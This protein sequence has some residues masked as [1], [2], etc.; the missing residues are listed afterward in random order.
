M[1]SSSVAKENRKQMNITIKS[2]KYFP[3]HKLVGVHFLIRIFLF[4]LKDIYFKNIQV[5]STEKV[6]LPLRNFNVILNLPFI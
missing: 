1:Q 2:L 3:F 4:F 5:N 6:I